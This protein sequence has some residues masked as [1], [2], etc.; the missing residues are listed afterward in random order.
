MDV[1]PGDTTVAEVA[2]AG[3]SSS[4]VPLRLIFTVPISAHPCP[5][6]ASAAARSCSRAM[7]YPRSP[8]ECSAGGGLPAIAGAILLELYFSDLGVSGITVVGRDVEFEVAP[9]RRSGN[10]EHPGFQ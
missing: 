3:K 1:F 2:A 8:G 10:R 5:C 6:A 4:S 9:C 7:R